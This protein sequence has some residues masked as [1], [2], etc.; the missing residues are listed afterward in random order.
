MEENLI[1][2]T[3]YI[4]KRIKSY[5]RKHH[6]TNRA[7]AKKLGI[8]NDGVYK[9]FQ[10]KDMQASMLLK[11]SKELDY[12]FFRDYIMQMENNV[13][14]TKADFHQENTRLIAENQAL[15]LENEIL[16]KVLNIVKPEG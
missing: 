11:I 8:T 16:K 14:K 10:R 9:L 4:G 12:D 2:A 5:C 15:K 3:I 1:E 7:L 13:Y 6:I